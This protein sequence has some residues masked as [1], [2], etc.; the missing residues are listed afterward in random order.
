MFSNQELNYRHV[1]ILFNLY[2]R[3]GEYSLANIYIANLKICL[4]QYKGKLKQLSDR[5]PFPKLVCNEISH[6][7]ITIH[8]GRLFKKIE[9]AESIRYSY[10]DPIE[11]W[12]HALLCLD[13]T[14]YIPNISRFKLC[15]VRPAG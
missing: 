14:S 6:D 12:L 4:N 13:V 5:N 2:Y 10:G 9:L 11:S 8:V 15:Y 1:Q 7:L 3:C